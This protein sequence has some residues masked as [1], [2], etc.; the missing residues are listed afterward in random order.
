M[1]TVTQA[2]VPR[3]IGQ[4]CPTTAQFSKGSDAA[5][6]REDTNTQRGLSTPDVP[7]N[8]NFDR[9]A[10]VPA[11][12]GSP[13]FS[14][15]S[16]SMHILV[17]YGLIPQVVRCPV[18][19]DLDLQRG[20]KVL[21]RTS[22][23]LELATILESVA[24]KTPELATG[25]TTAATPAAS[26]ASSQPTDGMAGGVATEESPLD[27]AAPAAPGCQFE[28][29][30]TAADVAHAVELRTAAEKDFAK[31]QQRFGDWKLQLELLDLEWTHDRGRLIV[32]VLGGRGAET[33]RLSLLAAA[34]GAGPIEVAPVSVDG[35][36]A[37]KESSGGG[38]SSGGCG[39]RK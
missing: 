3:T 30:A 20:D 12:S 7:L 28:R 25:V 14:L 6:G 29:V 9:T 24:T 37:P 8:Y 38:C 31:W 32:Y 39:C 10:V 15:P 5:R 1:T 2:V 4:Y 33:T 36:V 34:V 35:L 19:A 23:G 22:R 16:W 18:E 17:R 26:V 11:L 13:P 27:S 21:L